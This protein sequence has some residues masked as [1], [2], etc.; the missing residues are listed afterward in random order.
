MIDFETA[1]ERYRH[2]KLA[3]DDAVYQSESD[4]GFRNRAIGWMVRNFGIIETDPTP[5]VENYF[6]Q[7]SVLVTC[8]D[9]GMMGATL[10]NGGLNPLTGEA[11]PLWVAKYSRIRSKIT[12]VSV[13]E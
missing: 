13:V 11:L 10:A 6:R 8:R 3:I 2:W 4:T 7:C 1:P 9:L 12:T 5:V